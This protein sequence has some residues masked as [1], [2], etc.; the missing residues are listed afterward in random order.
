M[1]KSVIG[2]LTVI[3]TLGVAMAFGQMKPVG[4]KAAP[5]TA[6]AA[7][8]PVKVTPL[9][10]PEG[11][12]AGEVTGNLK[13]GAKLSSLR[14]AERSSVACFPG[15]RFEMFNGNTLFYRIT[16]P[17][18][19]K[20]KITVT[21]TGDRA[22]NLYALRQ[23]IKAQD[24]TVPPDVSSAISCEASYPIYANLG[25]GRRVANKDDGTRKVEY[26]SVG[27]PYSILI[28]VAGAEGLTEGEFKLG[29]EITSR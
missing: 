4:E 22:I 6:S 19:S 13:D 16:L 17:A 11:Y 21:P 28:G 27:S 20:I 14:W 24:Q 10:L 9:T 8:G 26:I 15:T 1:I 25:G 29:I 2:L 12:N 18:A 7:A 3:L 23:G 5:K